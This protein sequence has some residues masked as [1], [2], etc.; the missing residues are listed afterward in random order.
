MAEIVEHVGPDGEVSRLPAGERVLWSGAPDRRSLARYFLRERWV[1]G[2]VAA[3]FAIGVADALRYGDGVIPRVVGVATLSAVLAAVAVVSIRLFAWRLAK[4]SQYVITNRRVYFN[5]GI[6]LRADAN[7]PYSSVE[8]VD[9]LRRSDGSA[10]LMISLTG[11]QEIPWLLL[12]PHM[13][14]RGSKRGR[15]TFRALHDSQ[16]AADAVVGALRAYPQQA[17]GAG[18]EAALASPVSP[19]STSRTQSSMATPSPA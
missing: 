7:I 14:W 19:A 10:D 18:D 16:Q 11:T 8:G 5:I 2:F 15:P 6:V 12:F 3:S 4:S 13:T 1:L 9:L 17:P